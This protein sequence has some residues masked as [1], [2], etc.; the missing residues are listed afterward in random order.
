MAGTWS[1]KQVDPI[2]YRTEEQWPITETT[3][4]WGFEPDKLK[5]ADVNISAYWDDSSEKN[6]NNPELRWGENAKYTGENTKNTSVAYNKDATLEGLNPNYAYWQKAQM[7]NSWDAWYI[8]RRNDE[9]ASALYN[10]WKT[11]EADVRA[12]LEQQNWFMNSTANERENTIKSVWKRL[13]QI[14]SD[15]SQNENKNGWNTWV[16]N[17]ATKNMENDLNVDRSGEIYWKTTADWRWEDRAIKTLADANSVEA[18]INES[19]INNFKSLQAM[20]VSSIAASIVSWY[21]PY[22][23]QWMRDLMQYDPQKYNEVQA[24]VKEIKAQDNINKITSWEEITTSADIAKENIKNENER[25]A[26]SYATSETEVTELLNS[27]D[28]SLASNQAANTAEWTMD[29]IE[30]DM[31]KLK[32]RLKNLDNEARKI[33]KSDVPQ[34]L[35]N[36]YKANRTKEIQDKL[37]ELENRYNAAYDRY[38]TELDNSW[39]EKEYNLQLAKF[40]QDQDEFERKKQTASLDNFDITR[41]DWVPYQIERTSTWLRVR[42]LSIAEWI[43]DLTDLKVNRTEVKQTLKNIF[44]KANSLEDIGSLVGSIKQWI[45]W[46]QCWYFSNNLSYAMWSNVEFWSKL[47]EKLNPKWDYTKSDTPVV[48]SFAIFNSKNYPENWHVGMVTSINDDWSYTVVSSN[49][50][51]DE[52]VFYADYQP[53]DALTFIVPTAKF[54]WWNEKYFE[55]WIIVDVDVPDSIYNTWYKTVDPN[56]EEWQK[57]REEYIRNN[58]P[59]TSELWELI[60]DADWKDTAAYKIISAD[61]WTPIV[62]RQRIYNLVPST[63]KNSNVELENLYSIA[64]KLYEADYSADEAAMVFYGLDPRND[65]KWLLMPLVNAVRWAWIKIDENYY[66]SLWWLLQNWQEWAAVRTTENTILPDQYL[67]DETDSKSTIS[68][69]NDIINKIE[70]AQNTKDPKTWKPKYQWGIYSSTIDSLNT[71]YNVNNQDSTFADLSADIWNIYAQVRVQLMGTSQTWW[72]T[73]TYEA[74]FPDMKKDKVSTIMAK[75]NS[76]KKQLLN[77]VNQ[78]RDTYGLPALDEDSLFDINNRVMLYADNY[79]DLWWLNI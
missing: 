33:F 57:L 73:N 28:S 64:K 48:W 22:W 18:K 60:P 19:R 20:D 3:Q 11:S 29:N 16:D 13:W 49:N 8:Q 1:S 17:N 43:S 67:K 45:P 47:E 62:F 63:L 56:S 10:A 41:Q 58:Q 44:S 36:A 30:A 70:T 15:Q 66:G 37:S 27:V 72:E 53:W 39:K 9:I 35:V 7:V 23:D 51:W 2:A 52:Q 78:E 4:N 77:K 24:K 74:I 46:W 21:T 61:D 5:N 50:W 12:Y 34:Y 68:L 42:Q 59:E 40:K 38:K 55:D 31:E 76:T 75:L 79:W 14:S 25:Q 6:Y 32:T 65:K 71:K 69:I 54:N 26:E